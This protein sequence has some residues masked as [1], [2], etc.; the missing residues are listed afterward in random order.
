VL[1]S[2]ERL[3]LSAAVVSIGRLPECTIT[4]E[5]SNISRRHAEVRPRGT[6][7]V[8][9][10]LGSTNGTK[11]NGVRIDG[12]RLLREGDIISV[13]TTHIRFEAS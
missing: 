9:A 6:G 11:V 12:E 7:W 5:D 2:G 13:G 4:L 8:A 10:D 1:P 3:G